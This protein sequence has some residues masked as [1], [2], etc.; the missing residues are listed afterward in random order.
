MIMPKRTV[1]C[2]GMTG[3]VAS[4]ASLRK[5]KKICGGLKNV[6]NSVSSSQC[7]G[8]SELSTMAKTQRTIVLSLV[9]S[10][11]EYCTP[12][13]CRNAHTCLIESV[14]NCV[15]RIIT[16][17]LRPTPIEYHLVLS[18]IQPAKLRCQ[19]ATLSI[20]NRGCLGTD[21]ILQGQLYGT[22]NVK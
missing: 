4:H 3:V 21:H 2:Y 9:Y 7:R 19:G 17:Y 11:T 22:Q 16:G 6:K 18:D 20:A 12:I 1:K 5:L 15:L 8:R 10:T 13:W 14:L